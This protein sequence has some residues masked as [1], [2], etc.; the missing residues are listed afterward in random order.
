[1]SKNNT[2]EQEASSLQEQLVTWRRALHQI[3]E[4]GIRLPQTM[5]YIRQRLEEMG[6]SY[7]LHEDISCITAT[8]GS[9]GKCFLLRSDVDALPVAEEADVPFRATNGCMHGCGHDMHGTILLGAARL[10]KDH[11]SELKGTVKLLFQSG[12]EIFLGAKSAIAAG[13]LENPRVD[14]A[15]AMHV[16]AMMPMDLIFTGK[17]A[18]SAVDGFKITLIGHGGHGSMPEYTV[19]PINAAVQVYLALQSLIARE[20]GGSE[21]AVLTVGQFTAGEASNII[22]ERA[23]LQGTLRTFRED[24]RQRLVKRIREVVGGVAMTYRC[25]YEYEELFSCASVCT[26]DAVNA[27]VEKSIRKI[28]PGITIQKNAHGMGSEDFAEITQRVPSAYYTIGA[29]PEDESRRL[30]Q[31]NPKIEFNEDVLSV[32][33]A[34]YAQAAMDWLEE[35]S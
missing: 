4:T 20:I 7:E 32:G 8:I 23:V 5:Q 15:F 28:V 9:G 34:I 27:A 24:V 14:A 12:E 17:Q 21:E 19:D 1:M 33:A 26:D 31:H 11:E 6:I 30:G 25:R 18:M 35:N 3:P 2:F 10:L 16:I 29:G 13:V 22:P